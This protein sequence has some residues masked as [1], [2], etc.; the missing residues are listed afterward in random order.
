[1]DIC[2]LQRYAGRLGRLGTLRLTVWRIKT[3][4]TSSGPLSVTQQW[5]TTASRTS[6]S[7]NLR[8]WNE[9]G[10]LGELL[11]QLGGFEFVSPVLLYNDEGYWRNQL[12]SVIDGLEV[13]FSLSVDNKCG[14]HIHISTLDGWNLKILRNLAVSALA[15]EAQLD[16]LMS[17]KVDNV[18]CDSNAN[19]MVLSGLNLADIL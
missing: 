13:K 8:E 11:N 17:N 15:F 19:S 7:I 6:V 5:S 16:Q 2:R 3:P 12:E 14:T 18:F 1:M 9:I 10:S 4:N